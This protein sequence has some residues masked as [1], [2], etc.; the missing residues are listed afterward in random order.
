MDFLVLQH[1]EKSEDK[2]FCLSP[3]YAPPLGASDRDL[4]EKCLEHVKAIARMTRDDSE[5]SHGETSEFSFEI[6][7]IIE[8][9]RRATFGTEKASVH[10]L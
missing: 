6:M 5:V 9:Y 2:K 7:N 4:S 3:S 1:I 10:L 8:R